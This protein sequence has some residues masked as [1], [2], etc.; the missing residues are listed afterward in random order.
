MKLNNINNQTI[1]P[2][3]EKLT[4]DQVKTIIKDYFKITDQDLD[5]KTRARDIVE[6]RQIAHYFAKCY[7]TRSLATIGRMIGN[8]DH[9][10][11][12]HSCKVVSNYYETDP[13]FRKN[14]IRIDAIFKSY[15]QNDSIE[16]NAINFVSI[17]Q[18]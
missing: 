4:I 13:E 7:T 1:F 3:E 16:P 18:Y 17:P 12:L 6:K 8:K 11:V 5:L 15:Q 14:I 9:A 10:T 2:S